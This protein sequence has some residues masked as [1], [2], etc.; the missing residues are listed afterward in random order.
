MHCLISLINIDQHHHF[1]SCTPFYISFDNFVHITSSLLFNIEQKMFTLV[2]NYITK[3]K[4]I[5]QK[6]KEEE[7]ERTKKQEEVEE[8]EREMYTCQ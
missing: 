7:K 6:R 3:Y 2:K 4:I 5:K 8:D 1:L